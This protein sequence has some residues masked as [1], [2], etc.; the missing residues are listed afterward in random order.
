[1]ENALLKLEEIMERRLGVPKECVEEN[2]VVDSPQSSDPGSGDSDLDGSELESE[3]ESVSG[4][5]IKGKRPHVQVIEHDD[6]R[7]SRAGTSQSTDKSEFRSF[8]SSKVKLVDNAGSERLA[9]RF[10]S[11]KELDREK[12]D[13][14]NDREL[15]ALIKT[16]KIVEKFNAEQLTGKDRHKHMKHQLQKLGGKVCRCRV[17]T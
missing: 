4:E 14:N 15:E 1:M 3:V 17:N 7:F 9:K 2:V 8:M 6:S 11:S 13:R 10:K 5:G 16:S 12:L